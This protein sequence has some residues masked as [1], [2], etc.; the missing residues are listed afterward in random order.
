MF[1]Y[2]SYVPSRPY[3]SYEQ[4]LCNIKSPLLPTDSLAHTF[5]LRECPRR[6]LPLSSV[7]CWETLE[8]Q[9]LSQLDGRLGPNDCKQLL[10]HKDRR[11]YSSSFP[12]CQSTQNITSI[13][14]ILKIFFRIK[15]NQILGR[16]ECYQKKRG[17]GWRRV[18]FK[19]GA[20]LFL[21]NQC[22]LPS[23]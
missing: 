15:R 3:I 8:V 22:L 19:F 12:C 6:R 13:P 10:I 9:G 11:K 23:V 16:L 20:V 7:L 14:K 1:W 17:G 21:V 18:I 2:F 4:V 5:A